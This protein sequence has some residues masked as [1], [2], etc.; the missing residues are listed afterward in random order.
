MLPYNSTGIVVRKYAG[1]GDILNKKCADI[2]DTSGIFVADI[3][4]TL[5]TLM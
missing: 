2:I 5:D 1:I 4:D 3:A